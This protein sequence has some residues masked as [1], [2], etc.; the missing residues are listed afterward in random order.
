[1]IETGRMV[2]FDCGHERQ[3]RL[4]KGGRSLIGDIMRC[5]H[6]LHHDGHGPDRR[7]VD[8]GRVLNTISRFGLAQ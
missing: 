2:E 6:H 8:E 4:C 3:L 5:S 7:V 1:M